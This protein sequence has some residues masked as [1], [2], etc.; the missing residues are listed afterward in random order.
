MPVFAL[1]LFNGNMNEAALT[2]YAIKIT[3]WNIQ[4]IILTIILKCAKVAY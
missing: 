3:K 2:K 1:W 4:N